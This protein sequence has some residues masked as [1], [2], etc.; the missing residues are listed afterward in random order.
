MAH[1]LLCCPSSRLDSKVA[2]TGKTPASHPHIHIYLDAETL[3]TS[4]LMSHYTTPSAKW[5]QTKILREQYHLVPEVVTKLKPSKRVSIDASDVEELIDV[6]EA[7]D[8]DHK[9]VVEEGHFIS[10]YLASNPERPRAMFAAALVSAPRPQGTPAQS[11]TL[12]P[13]TSTHTPGGNTRSSRLRS[14]IGVIR[15]PPQPSTNPGLDDGADLPRDRAVLLPQDRA[16][17]AQQGLDHGQSAR[18]T[19]AQALSPHQAIP[20][21]E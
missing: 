7:V 11:R 6:F 15:S 20:G 19:P 10:Y 5:Q 1:I 12:P 4:L 8:V 17:P 13:F 3:L 21:T 16:S 2:C 18:D 9:D 14:R